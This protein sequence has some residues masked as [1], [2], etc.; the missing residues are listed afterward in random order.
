MNK[1]LHLIHMLPMAAIAIC[2]ISEGKPA[3]MA[4]GIVLGGFEIALILHGL[5]DYFVKRAKWEP[6][7][8]RAYPDP[9]EDE[10]DFKTVETTHQIVRTLEDRFAEGHGKSGYLLAMVFDPNF[11]WTS[12]EVKRDLGASVEKMTDY[13]KRAFPILLRQAEANLPEAMHLVMQY[14]QNGLPPVEQDDEKMRFWYEKVRETDY[15]ATGQL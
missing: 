9:F 2:L 15:E 6:D 8:Y 11:L 5:Y 13:Y 12:D 14:Y 3:L 10:S 4:F 1:L 7:D